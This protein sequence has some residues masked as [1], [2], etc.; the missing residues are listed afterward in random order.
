MYCNVLY[1]SCVR[2]NK[3]KQIIEIFFAFTKIRQTNLFLFNVIQTKLNLSNL[4]F[5]LNLKFSWCSTKSEIRVILTPSMYVWH[6]IVY[7][8]RF[9]IQLTMVG[10]QMLIS[11]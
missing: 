6:L 3:Q 8:H 10:M 5:L 2:Y 11:M 9:C 1:A 7:L 4:H